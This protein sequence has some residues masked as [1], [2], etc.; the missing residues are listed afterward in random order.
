LQT[1]NPAQVTSLRF[2]D[3]AAA[4]ADDDGEVTLDELAEAP[5]DVTQYD[6]SG[7]DAVNHLDFVR[8]LVRTIGHFRGEGE[9]TIGA[10]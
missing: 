2:D 3:L 1:A 8:A 4:D 10:L 7:L 5:L 9:C 6:P